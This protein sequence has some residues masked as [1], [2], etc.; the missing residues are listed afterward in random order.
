MFSQVEDSVVLS[1]AWKVWILLQFVQ[2]IDETNE[3]VPKR[4]FPTPLPFLTDCKFPW[5]THKSEKVEEKTEK[6][7]HFVPS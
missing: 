5:E 4:N 1:F 7:S 2:P 3:I 6:I